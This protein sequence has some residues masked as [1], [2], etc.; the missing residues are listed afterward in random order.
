MRPMGLSAAG[1]LAIKLST[2]DAVVGM[3]IVSE[4]AFVV[5][6]SEKGYAKRTA[7]KNF[8]LQ[9]RY[10]GGVQA[11]KVTSRTGPLAVAAL[12]GE[13]DDVVLATSTGSVIKLPIQTIH[14]QGRAASG[15]SNRPDT[16]EPYM[17]PEV[18]GAPTLLT[19]LAGTKAAAKSPSSRKTGETPPRHKTST[20]EKS[21]A[22]PVTSTSA[23]QAKAP[24]RSTGGKATLKSQPT[25][26]TASS[27]KKTTSRS[28]PMQDKNASTQAPE[29]EAEAP[30]RAISNQG[31]TVAQMP[32]PLVSAPSKKSTKTTA[33]KKRTVRSVPRS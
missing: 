13:Q 23:P 6:F 12:A 10:G 14:S 7:I 22:E 17:E 33:R 5:T 15:S 16:K 25:T 1:V 4:D 3:G 18:H 11:A 28:R 8:P 19:V 26:R 31:E 20:A 27:R 29:A 21:S 9:K 2:D 32:L 30:D 24:A